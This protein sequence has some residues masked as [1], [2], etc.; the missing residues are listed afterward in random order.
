VP[1]TAEVVVVGGGIGGGALA[2]V[3]ARAGLSMLVLEKSTQH[4]DRV[5]GEWL[6]PW[7]VAET[8]RLG[9]YESLIGAGA[10]HLGE[11]LGFGDDVDEA[12]PR[13]QALK[14]VAFEGAG[15][16][17]PL[18]MRHPDMCNLL[19][20]TEVKCG[21]TV[22]REVSD[23]TA[24]PGSPRRLNSGTTVARNNRGRAWS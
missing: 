16:K 7:G 18:C 8:M 22:L 3:L 14:F 21:A 12:T 20:A 1:E 15:F 9:L 17:P 11:H 5:R 6:S 13:D 4:V 24:K 10:H 2:T 19:D 23:L